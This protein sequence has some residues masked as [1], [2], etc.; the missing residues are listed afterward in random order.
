[1]NLVILILI[2]HL[3]CE[4]IARKLQDKRD[5]KR[6]KELI[7]L[8]IKNLEECKE[9]MEKMIKYVSLNKN[10]KEIIYTYIMYIDTQI[11]NYKLRYH[12]ID[13]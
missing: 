3:V 2:L 11:F 1:M 13:E 9:N 12:M 7:N 10:S 5:K 4:N 8:Q 6:F